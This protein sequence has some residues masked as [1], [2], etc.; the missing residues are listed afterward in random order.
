MPMPLQLEVHGVALSS[1]MQDLV[2]AQLRKLEERHGR[3]TS[4]HVV[5]RAPGTHHRMGEPFAVSIRVALPGRREVNVG[6]ISNSHD[7]RQ[8]DIVF[9]VNDAFRRAVRQLQRQAHRLENGGK[10]HI[11]APV[12]RIIRLAPEKSC[13][14]LATE[15]GHEIYFHAHSVLGGR[16]AQLLPGDRVA[17][18][19]EKGEHGPQASTVRI[20]GGARHA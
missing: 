13:G 11:G 17:Y 10:Q 1:H 15:D 2:A 9:A 14:F 12:G 3:V 6:R 8:S 4:C 20:L 7:P 16:F 19:E 5:I 18:H